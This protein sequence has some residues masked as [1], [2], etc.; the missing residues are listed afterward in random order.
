MIN[1]IGNAAELV[2]G[3][4][5]CDLGILTWAH[6]RNEVANTMATLHDSVAE[7]ACRKQHLVELLQLV[8]VS[9]HICRVVDL[10]LADLSQE[11]GRFMLEE[12]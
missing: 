7:H 11:H 3:E 10:S 12:V 4:Q 5:P 6:V 1:L 8:H 9:V 2:P